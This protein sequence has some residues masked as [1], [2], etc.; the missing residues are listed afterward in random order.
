MLGLADASSFHPVVCGRFAVV[1]IHPGEALHE[2]DFA[3]VVDDV[4]GLGSVSANRPLG[5]RVAV[6][7]EGHGERRPNA[8]FVS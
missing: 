5:L 3:V 4:T 1:Q 6:P 8:I 7:Y 2:L